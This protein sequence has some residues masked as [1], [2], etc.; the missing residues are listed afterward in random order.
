[1]STSIAGARSTDSITIADVLHDL[2]VGHSRPLSPM[3]PAPARPA[4]TR[5][6]LG[7]RAFLRTYLTA[8]VLG[9][10]H[11]RL[12]RGALL[13]LWFTP[14]VHP[15]ANEPVTGL[16]ADLA[17]WSLAVG[18]STLHGYAGGTG[19]TVVL[20]HG[21]AGRA[22]DWRHLADPLLA[23][24]WRVVAPD[25]PA[26][27]ATAGRT[28]DLFDVAQAL[29]AVL[30]HEVPE[31]VVTHSMGFPATMLAIEA[32]A[33]VPATIVALAPGRRIAGAVEGFGRRA[34]LRP[35]LVAELRRGLERRF[36]ED[37]WDVLE[38][39]RSLPSLTADG[40]VVH[41]TDDDEVPLTDARSIAELWP[42]ARF[43]A[44]DGHGHRRILRAAAVHDL[45]VR[46][47]PSHR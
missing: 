31:A 29:A 3:E 20:V 28:T 2:E 36:G 14:W 19:P 22:A 35:A 15:S 18:R 41:D 33:R 11:P 27:G 16:P 1:M 39:D 38:V 46:S 13:R 30:D 8:R 10:L 43:V 21:W 6:T 4:P 7:G 9:R 47:L 34:R 24:G 23:A 45:I 40:L 12:A 17:P 26:H 44:S 42:N 32:G 5:A 25:L 37:V